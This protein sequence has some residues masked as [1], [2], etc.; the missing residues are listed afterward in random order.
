MFVRRQPQ[1]A[2]LFPVAAVEEFLDGLFDNLA[3]FTGALLDA[4][5]NFL[6]LAF[7]V[8][9][10]VI[11]ERGPFLFQPA[12]GDV[13]VASDFECCLKKSWF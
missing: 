3:G 7:S 12:L 11:R 4:A 10:V 8:L 6:L 13:P 5:N 9:E 1:N 2:P